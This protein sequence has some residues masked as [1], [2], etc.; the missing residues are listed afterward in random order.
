[1]PVTRWSRLGPLAWTY[2]TAFGGATVDQVR[3]ASEARRSDD[4]PRLVRAL[5]VAAAIVLL[6]C[7]LLFVCSARLRRA[8][9]A[10][11]DNRSL[12]VVKR[13]S[14]W[15]DAVT[16]GG[17]IA[18]PM[19]VWIGVV[20]GTMQ[21]AVTTGSGAIFLLVY[22]VN[23]AVLGALA[24]WLVAGLLLLLVSSLRRGRAMTATGPETPQ[25]ERWVVEG[26]AARSERD[27]AAAFRLAVRAVGS[28]P[29]GKVIVAVARTDR[30]KE[31]Y[32]RLGFKHGALNRVFAVT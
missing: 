22:G 9:Y 19:I 28:A 31:A 30:L 21:L 7:A 3:G 4:V 25:G 14:S 10:A 8:L 27:G 17:V 13:V 29:E 2:A 20:L 15:K 16:V 26:L 23:S 12:V 24:A 32:A 18:V 1:M 6:P 5:R 11:D